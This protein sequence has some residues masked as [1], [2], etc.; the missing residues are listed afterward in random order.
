MVVVRLPGNNSILPYFSSLSIL[1]IS[2]S[3]L[4]GAQ[5]RKGTGSRVYP[6]GFSGVCGVCGVRVLV[7]PLPNHHRVLSIWGVSV[8]MKSVVVQS[9]LWLMGT[10]L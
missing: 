4:F 2:L 7:R 1:A 6:L 9:I 8:S 3:P 10:E 5:N